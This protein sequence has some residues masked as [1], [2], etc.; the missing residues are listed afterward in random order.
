MTVNVGQLVNE[1]NM[2]IQYSSVCMLC[3]LGLMLNRCWCLFCY[4]HVI[5]ELTTWSMLLTL[6][7]HI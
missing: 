3:D 4:T 5:H 1:S 6:E 7:L 2:S